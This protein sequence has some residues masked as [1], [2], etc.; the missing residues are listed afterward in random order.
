MSPGLSISTYVTYT[1]KRASISY[2]IIPIEINGKIFDYRVISTLATEYII[3]EP[4]SIDFGT[5]DIGYSSGL[6]IV[7]IRNEGSKSTRY[8]LYYL[9]MSRT[10]KIKITFKMQYIFFIFIERNFRLRK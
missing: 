4:K 3:I 6:K 5:I 7:T 1:F 10:L 2:A 8:S 9:E